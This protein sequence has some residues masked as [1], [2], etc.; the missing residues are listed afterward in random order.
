MA[1]SATAPMAAVAP[2]DH[3]AA[4]AIYPEL[5]PFH[6]IV[7]GAVGLRVGRY[8]SPGRCC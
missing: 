1:S 5:L 6:D 4:A 3:E 2:H 8:G 7:A